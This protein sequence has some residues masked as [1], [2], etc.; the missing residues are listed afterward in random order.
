MK[1]SNRRTRP[2]ASRTEPRRSWAQNLGASD[3]DAGVAGGAKP[4]PAGSRAGEPAATGTPPRTHANADAA[5]KSV[6]E[7]YRLIDDYVRQGQRFAENLWLPFQGASGRNQEAFNA[8]GR[9]LRAMSD[10]TNAWLEL[11]QQSAGAG[12]REAERAPVGTAGPFAA[13]S[14]RAEPQ[15]VGSRA[16]VPASPGNRR[17]HVIVRSKGR[18]EVNLELHGPHDAAA[19]VATEL[20]SLRTGTEPVR[21]ITV[22]LTEGDAPALTI[23]VP[24]DQPPG[25]YNGLLLERTTQRPCGTISLSVAAD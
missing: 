2:V 8:P 5:Y 23:V 9:L 16:D 18:V 14:R 17:L 24:D 21:D 11:M 22:S 3:S 13:A 10:M 20:R 6:S 19:L 7:A 25:I 1:E 4:N 12:D 15:T